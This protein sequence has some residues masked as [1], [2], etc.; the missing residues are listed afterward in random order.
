MCNG[1]LQK[2]KKTIILHT[3][4]L[5]LKENSILSIKLNIKFILNTKVIKH[6][7]NSM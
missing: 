7:K 1:F 5:S 4:G 2:T 3:Q 6:K